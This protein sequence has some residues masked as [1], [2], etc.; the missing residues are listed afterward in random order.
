MAEHLDIDGRVIIPAHEL[1]WTAARASG[2][3]GQNVNKVATKVD[4]RFELLT[5]EAL[6]P[7]VK[8]RL[9]ALPGVRIDAEGRL[10]VTCQASRS[11]ADN[12]ADAR[13]KLS[14]LVRQALDPPKRRRPTR[15]SAGAKRRRLEAKR[16]QA[17]KKGG[18]ARVRQSDD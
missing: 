3:G 17:E 1:T 12:L 4:L 7:A 18:R 6:A 13:A 2:P 15:P 11:Q 5:S 8:A 16:Q 9:R 14:A 10:V